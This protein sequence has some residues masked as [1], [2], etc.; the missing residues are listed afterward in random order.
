M[1]N[2]Q[3]GGYPSQPTDANADAPRLWLDP[4]M[5]YYS[6]KIST[7]HY[8]GYLAFFPALRAEAVRLLQDTRNAS[9]EAVADWFDKLSDFVWRT[10]AA[11]SL[12]SLKDDDKRIDIQRDFNN[13]MLTYNDN[14]NLNHIRSD[15]LLPLFGPGHEADW[16][17]LILTSNHARAWRGSDLSQLMQGIECMVGDA[18]GVPL[19][20]FRLTQDSRPKDAAARNIIVL[21]SH[22][23][24]DIFKNGS[25]LIRRRLALEND[26]NAEDPANRTLDHISPAAMRL[27]KLMLK[28]MADPSSARYVDLDRANTE[29]YPENQGKPFIAD[30]PHV[31]ERPIVLRADAAR[32]AQHLKL[33]GYSKSANTVADALR[34]FYQ[35]CARLGP[36]LEIDGKP[37]SAADIR[38]I[39]SNMPILSINPG[40]VPL[41][42][43]EKEILGMHRTTILNDNDLTAGHLVKPDR[44]RYDPWQDKLIVIKGSH[45]DAGHNLVSALGKPGLPGYIMD[46]AN[47]ADPD[48]QRAQDE[49]KAYFASNLG[50][51]ALNTICFSHDSKTRDNELY[52]Q[53]NP[54]ISRVDSSKLEAELLEALHAYGF[55]KARAFSDLTHRRRMQ[56][57]LDENT[58]PIER[59]P[60]AIESCKR[61][62]AALEA[63]EGGSL[64]I[65]H[66]V[67]RYL[68]ETYARAIPDAQVN[69][70]QPTRMNGHDSLARR[71]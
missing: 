46:Q 63:R 7:D 15:H 39:I 36:R 18:W 9:T 56:I 4:E 58:D 37:A 28:L 48:Y 62:F 2:I 32:I 41:T 23:E 29:D 57:I 14:G 16:P 43:A 59:R 61:A 38:T 34:F 35:E 10:E 52:L 54:G 20:S 30:D 42:K 64:F 67:A 71:P 5:L 25:S 26:P 60:Q 69:G 66:D 45:H 55:P 17:N 11:M 51:H 44:S 19:D 70:A 12:F 49:V 1:R 6:G 21:A 50:K 24:R 22:T 13:R 40:E 31:A 27:G 3:E 33:V 53:F 65:T 8:L 68:D 47:A